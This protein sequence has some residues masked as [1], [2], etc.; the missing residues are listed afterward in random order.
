MHNQ[1]RLVHEHLE[2]MQR[3]VHGLEYSPWKRE[4]ERLWR[5]I[6]EQIAKMRE[7]P[8][9]SSLQKIREPWTR[10]LTHYGAAAS[11]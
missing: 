6:F 3:D 10:Y 9:Q 4:V 7:G 11:Q 8:Q 2:A 5:G 1:L